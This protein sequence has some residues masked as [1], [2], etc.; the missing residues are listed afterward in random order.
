[1]DLAR[2]PE[3]NRMRRIVLKYG[4]L[5]GLELMATSG[6]DCALSGT[7]NYAQREIIGYATIFLSMLFVYFG[8]KQYRD[9]VN[10]GTMSFLQG[11]KLGVLISLLPSVAFGIFNAIYVKYLDPGF[12]DRYYNAA[13]AQLK[14]TLPPAEFVKQLKEMESKSCHR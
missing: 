2:I 4:G 5:G 12:V 10:G 6:I 1:M 8:M 9:K 11:L 14:A 3:I 13:V 7:Q